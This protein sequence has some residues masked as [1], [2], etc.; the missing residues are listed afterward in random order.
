MVTVPK[1][2]MNSPDEQNMHY[3]KRA[4]LLMEQN[5]VPPTPEN[6]SV[7]FQYAVGKNHELVRE[8][9]KA[10]KQ[11]LKFNSSTCS[12]LYNTFAAGSRTQRA[13][14]DAAASAQ[15]VLLDVLK[16][17]TE[18]S[19]EQQTYNKDV[20]QYLGT[21]TKDFD[22]QNVKNIVKELVQAT[23]SLK[24]SGESINKKLEESK[25]EITALKQNLQQVTM[26][27]QRDFLTGLYNRKSLEQMFEEYSKVANEKKTELCLM[28]LDIDHFKKFNDNYGHLLGDE[29][30][31]IVGKTLTDVL[32]G[33]DIVAR[34]GGEEFT[35]VLPET[36]VDG[37][38]KVAE[39]IRSTIASKELKRKDTG[40]TFGTITVSVGVARWR[41]Q[42]DSL[43]NIIKRADAALYHAKRL[44]RNCVIREAE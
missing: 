20:D 11:A 38:M 17:V 35:V 5:H 36:S 26:E 29:V 12:Y 4:L 31:K 24:K 16:V 13:V 6:Y 3:A 32:K 25:T 34:F 23:T 1:A 7:W 28:M 37:A 33:R 18:F 2:V 8:I 15:K 19:G 10:I 43:N 39:I 40:E 41:T 14:D 30:L 21:I 44:G 22:D 42:A 9:D 27:A